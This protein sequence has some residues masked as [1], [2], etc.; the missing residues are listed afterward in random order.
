[1]EGYTIERRFEPL[2]KFLKNYLRALSQWLYPDN[3]DKVYLVLWYFIVQDFENEA[4]QL[5][6]FG[7]RAEAKAM[8]LLQAL[9]YM[10]EFIHDG[11]DGLSIDQIIPPAEHVMQ[12]LQLYSWSTKKLIHLYRRLVVQKSRENGS[13][14]I[15][16]ELPPRET[17]KR[18][19]HDLHTIRKC[20]SGKQLVDWILI[21]YSFQGTANIGFP[22]E[23]LEIDEARLLAQKLLDLGVIR[24][25]VDDMNTFVSPTR[26]RSSTTTD[27]SSPLPSP[28]PEVTFHSRPHS[29]LKFQR[30]CN[31]DGNSLER[32]RSSTIDT[33]EMRSCPEHAMD[34]RG[35]S[36]DCVRQTGA[37]SEVVSDSMGEIDAMN[38]V[39]SEGV[40][41]IGARNEVV[42]EV[43]VHM[44]EDGTKEGRRESS[45]FESQNHSEEVGNLSDGGQKKR[46]SERRGKNLKEVSLV[47][48]DGREGLESVNTEQIAVESGGKDPSNRDTL[49]DDDGGVGFV[50]E[51]TN[52]SEIGGGDAGTP[53]GNKTQQ[54]ASTSTTRSSTPTSSRTTSSV[55]SSG[56][57]ETL[58]FIYSPN[59][60]YRFTEVDDEELYSYHSGLTNYSLTDYPSDNNGNDC[61]RIKLGMESKAMDSFFVLSVI[62]C[63]KGKDSKSRRF[64]KHV[65]KEIMDEFN[66]R[67][68][69]FGCL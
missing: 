22:E 3:Y 64:L 34:E 6:R 55:G 25:A 43:M 9:S 47:S 51:S 63:R 14:D 15:S 45:V 33:D 38:E 28:Y 19:R 20:F 11:G 61:H 56:H 62:Y 29:S 5:R 1:M 13:L 42:G 23:R 50:P 49:P 27:A 67:K 37:R 16:L 58:R 54:S 18:M 57:M 65:P 48:F 2:T 59:H 7:N 12:L 35:G 52:D 8:L 69:N 32:A 66:N 39:V 10:I 46:L 68:W 30:S 17:L 26:A 44:A 53:D 24:Q 60:L 36:G 21:N 31:S 4:Y 40:G 41:Q